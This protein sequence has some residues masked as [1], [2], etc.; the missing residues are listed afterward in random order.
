MEMTG[1]Q[2]LV[3][4]LAREGVRDI[5]GIP[6]VQLDWAVDAVCDVSA[7]MR[8]FVPRHEQT[9]SYMAD[10]YARTTGRE[11]VCMVVPGPGMLN[12]LSGL[13]TS[14]ACSAPV[15]FIA[16]QI[17][18]KTIGKGYGQLHEIP[19]QSAILRALTKW[20]GLAR[21]AA[22]VAPL[23]HEA[24]VQLR[25]GHPRPVA[26]EVPPDVLESKTSATLFGAAAR[27]PTQP[28]EALVARAAALLRDAK[29]PVIHIGGGAAAAD[30]GA[31]VRK[32]AEGLQAP[33][34]MTEGARGVLPSDHALALPGLGGRAVY[35]KADVILV[36]GSRFL[37]AIARPLH[38]AEGVHY[39][40]VNV[41]P[42]H[43]AAPRRPGLEIAGDAAV[44]IDAIAV[45][46]A[47]Y[48]AP[49][50][51][52][53]VAKVKAWCAAQFADVQ[54]QTQF[55]DALRDGMSDDTIV[56]SELTQVG[57]YANA[58]LP[59]SNPRSY[60]TPGYQGT[61]GY[62]FPTALGVAV[63]NPDRFVVSLTGDGGFG[64]G[65]QELATAAR[66]KLKLAVI[67]FTDGQFGNVK[68]IQQRVFGRTFLTDV[69]NPDF[70]LLAKAFKV[71]HALAE[72]PAAVAK[73]L[74][75]A[76]AYDGPTLIEV[77][78]GQMDSPWPVIHSFVQPAKPPP[79]DPLAHLP[80]AGR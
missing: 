1:G 12:A 31:A 19:D 20:H 6:G 7:T 30:A 5:F 69:E 77:P 67:V 25:S 40:Y 3:G 78:V 37:D 51:A 11:G 43:L 66:Y 34:V 49:S 42:N 56:V 44:T 72:S 71:R 18:S 55:V 21:S 41:D 36:A 29:F 63:G 38:A 39:I 33:V 65:M 74:K 15:L 2:A 46:L 9:A 22:E 62:G 61:L 4:Q 80:S 35:P 70:A 75:G 53:D 26:I 16:G 58:A 10:G 52:D 64:W 79:G 14:Y 45:A 59:V 60:V 28:S 17:P 13:A 57:Y 23:V 68:R 27:A 8:F 50:R 54:P 32:L 73:A 76:R 48:N 47:G 24:F